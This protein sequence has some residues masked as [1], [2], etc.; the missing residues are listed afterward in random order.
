M[1]NTHQAD[2]YLPREMRIAR[3]EQE[4]SDVF[5]LHLEF[6][7]AEQ[8]KN[9]HVLPGQFNMLYA[10]G[11]GEIP[12]SVVSDIDDDV[13]LAHTIRS[14]GS[15]TD[16]LSKLQE[17]DYI[18]LRGPFGHGWPLEQLQG[19]NIIV[20]TGGIGT[21]P[22]ITAVNEI[23]K[24][25]SLYKRLIVLHG[26]SRYTDFIYK[27]QYDN[28]HKAKDTD[29]YLSCNETVANEG[30]H[31]GLVTDLLEHIKLA[32]LANSTCIMC[33]PQ[34]MMCAA[35]T[36]LLEMQLSPEMIF[37]SLERNMHCGLGH[38]GHCQCGS[39]FVCKDGP[40]FPWTEISTY[41]QSDL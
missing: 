2:P 19:K 6:T 28:W 29:V 21:A 14:L 17:G 3:R 8:A 31:H 34:K 33:G 10:Y 30:W 41:I 5:T 40:V 18:G 11:I 7:D 9:Y 23:I 22:V 1:N 27:K 25:R 16:A 38:C 15:A 32:D 20:I 35:V 36:K 12:I 37:L 24:Y 26:V 39:R 4:S 13:P